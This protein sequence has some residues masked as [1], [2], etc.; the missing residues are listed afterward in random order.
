MDLP[1]EVIPI[2]FNDLIDCGSMIHD[3]LP[4]L[5]NRYKKLHGGLKK[6]I[7]EILSGGTDNSS[8]E[9]I[10]VRINNGPRFMPRR[11]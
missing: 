7:R 3:P 9:V 1:L 8:S 2:T 6:E 11:P 10:P 4:S 5:L